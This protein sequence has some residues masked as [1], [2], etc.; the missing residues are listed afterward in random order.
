MLA[1]GRGRL[2]GAARRLRWLCLL[3]R[4]LLELD[5]WVA[6]GVDGWRVVGVWFGVVMELG[7]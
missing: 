2:G 1:R 4:R 5:G 6:R 3:G 7:S